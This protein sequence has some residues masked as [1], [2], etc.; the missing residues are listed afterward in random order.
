MN[1]SM[2]INSISMPN[3]LLSIT[4]NHPTDIHILQK[5]LTTNHKITKVTSRKIE[6][7]NQKTRI[8]IKLTIQIVEVKPDYENNS[9][10]VRGR[11]VNEIENIKIGSYHNFTLNLN[12]NFILHVTNS[13]QQII[14]KLLQLL[15]VFLLVV[16]RNGKFEVAAIDEYGIYLKGHL[17]NKELKKFLAENCVAEKNSKS[18]HKQFPLKSTYYVKYIISNYELNNIITSKVQFHK[19]ELT[20]E[21]EKLH[22]SEI[23]QKIIA[24]KKNMSI[25][26]VK[27][28]IIANNFLSKYE[29]GSDLI[30]LGLNDVIDAKNNSAIETLILTQ[31]L[32]CS[33]DPKENNNINIHELI[34][35]LSKTI[36]VI[37]I[38]DT[39]L[40]G[41][42]LNDIGGI[43][44][45][46]NYNFRKFYE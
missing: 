17:K 7:N 46:L 5:I 41:K 15:D 27:D 43:G 11:V 29:K 30:A 19:I 38:S 1:P 4:P 37:C 26:F 42:K 28:L 32:Y 10:N 45:I 24:E 40:C 34:K 6:I 33:F 8:T 36:R 21:E 3:K 31:K 12:E 25:P 23:F 14:D 39:H 20:K 22:L 18:K 13:L 16:F 44:A 35:S 9:L 2:I